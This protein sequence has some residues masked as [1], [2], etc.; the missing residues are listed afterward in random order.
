MCAYYPE[1]DHIMQNYK[2][3]FVDHYGYCEW[4]FIPCAICGT[5]AIE[6]HHVT[7]KSETKAKWRD[8]V[9]NLLP[10]CSLCHM[11]CEAR[12]YTPEEQQE[13]RQKWHENQWNY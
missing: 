13:Y 7:K 4:E 1:W 6:L 3:N 10:L 2:K 8:N 12:K 11:D 5:A 9:E